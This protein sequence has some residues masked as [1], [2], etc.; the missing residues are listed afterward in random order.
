MILPR[1]EIVFEIPCPRIVRMVHGKSYER[2]FFGRKKEDAGTE[3][4]KVLDPSPFIN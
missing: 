2:I 1:E 3:R 4:E